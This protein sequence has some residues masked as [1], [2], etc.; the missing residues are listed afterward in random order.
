MARLT[1]YSIGLGLPLLDDTIKVSAR[2]VA[3]IYVNA[4]MCVNTNSFSRAERLRFPSQGEI[5]SAAPL[6]NVS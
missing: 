1:L 4:L 2:I 6:G 5:E 3:L